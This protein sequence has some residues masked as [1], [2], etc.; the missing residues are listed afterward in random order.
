[1]CQ[2][3]FNC[4][5]QMPTEYLLLYFPTV[6]GLYNYFFQLP[7]LYSCLFQL[8]TDS[9]QLCLQT[10]NLLFNI[11]SNCQPTHYNCIFKLPIGSTT[12]SSSNCQL[13][14][15]NCLFPLSTNSTSV[16]SNCQLI[17]P[18][19]LLTAINCVQLTHPTAS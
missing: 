12:I 7:T 1:M 4:L 16:S 17:Y 10:A 14:I 2:L 9:L 19:V 13:H 18:I 5:F 6:N 11:S 3:I 15:S 8:P